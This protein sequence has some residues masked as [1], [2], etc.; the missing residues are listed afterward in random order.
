MFALTGKSRGKSRIAPKRRELDGR[1]VVP[2]MLRRPARLFSKIFAG[3]I[4]VPRYAEAAGL[5]SIFAATAIYGA[6]AGGQFG[7]LA[8]DMTAKLGFAISEIEI[9]G[10]VNTS[11]IAVIEALGLTGKVPEGTEYV[12]VPTKG[13]G[14]GHPLSEEKLSRVLALYGAKDF[15]EAVEITSRIQRHQGAGHSVGLHTGDDARPMVL[16]RAVP[17]SRVIVNQAHTFATGGSFTNGMKFSLSMGCGAW[18]GNS[19]ND[20]VHWKHFLQT[21]RI[22]REIPPN[23]PSLEEIFSDYWKA[24]GS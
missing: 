3:D 6:V 8:N 1:L 13:I 20:N 22:V 18:G 23:E 16:A 5:A 10:Q 24:A 15:E 7:A 9:S 17:T 11:E 4:T 12:A 2:R 21:T 19:V 14:P